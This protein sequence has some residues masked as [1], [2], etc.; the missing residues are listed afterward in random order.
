MAMFIIR[1][2]LHDATGQDYTTLAADLAAKGITDVIRASNGNDYKMS[3]GEYNYTGSEA[4]DA[5]LNAVQASANRTGRRNAVFV[6]EAQL[7][8]WN[9]LPVVQSRR[10]A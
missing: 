10:T 6:T 9:G 8:K 4:I 2:E 1:A 5:V 7:T 3:P